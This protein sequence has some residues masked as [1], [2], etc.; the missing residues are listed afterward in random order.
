MAESAAPKIRTLD[1]AERVTENYHYRISFSKGLGALSPEPH[2]LFAV[3]KGNTSRYSLLMGVLFSG[4]LGSLET[5]HASLGSPCISHLAQRSILTTDVKDIP[6]VRESH[7]CVS[8]YVR[9]LCVFSRACESPCGDTFAKREKNAPTRVPLDQR[10]SAVKQWCAVQRGFYCIAE[11]AKLET[12]CGPFR[13][14]G[15]SAAKLPLN[16][17]LCANL[18]LSPRFLLFS[19]FFA[20]PLFVCTSM[21]DVLFG[22]VF[23]SQR[24]LHARLYTWRLAQN[25]LEELD[26]GRMRINLW[27]IA[28]GHGR[29]FKNIN[30]IQR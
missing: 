22:N 27:R 30:S 2:Y 21:R 25:D 29:N 16:T 15:F 18:L 7:V 13:S 6:E 3:H 23:L 4:A 1:S 20:R 11:R 12:Q 14:S 26:A 24:W 8:I 5:C 19:P 9:L 17:R 10:Q 28:L